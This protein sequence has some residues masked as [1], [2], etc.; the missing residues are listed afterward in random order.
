[1]RDS[2]AL[3]HGAPRPPGQEAPGNESIPAPRPEDAGLH[4]SRPGPS[5][6]RNLVDGVVIATIHHGDFLEGR[7]R[8]GDPGT[9]IR[10]DRREDLPQGR[11]SG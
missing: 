10:T 5:P 7:V 8:P 9:G 4:L 11:R 2:C 1:M 6:G 3:A